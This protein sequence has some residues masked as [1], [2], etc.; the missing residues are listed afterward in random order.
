MLV[1]KARKPVWVSE[2]LTPV[3]TLKRPRV[4]LLPKRLRRGTLPVK[5]RAPRISRLG[6]S[7]ALLATRKISQTLCW[8]SASAVTTVPYIFSAWIKVKAVFSACPLPWLTWWRSTV[9]YCSACTKTIW[10]LEE[11][12]SSITMIWKSPLWWIFFISLMR[13]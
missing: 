8:P 5:A 4:R 11:L 3:W 9:A 6:F 2:T 7:E 1:V 10:H 13:L 12:P